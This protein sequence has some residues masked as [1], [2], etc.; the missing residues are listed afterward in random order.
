MS[1]LLVFPLMLLPPFTLQGLLPQGDYALT[2]DELRASHLVTGEGSGSPTWDN[3]WR[4]QLVNNLEV[5]V[6]Q[7]WAVGVE[8]VF[9]DGSFAQVLDA[10]HERVMTHVEE[11]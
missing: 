6:R 5:P 8:R 2:F 3:V 11:P 9:A 4:L 7:L 1:A 10:L